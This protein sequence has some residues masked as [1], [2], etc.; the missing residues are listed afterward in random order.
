MC[1][2]IWWLG[3]EVL[4]NQF[5]LSQPS[6]AS[7]HRAILHAPS[8]IVMTKP[9]LLLLLLLLLILLSFYLSGGRLGLATHSL[10]WLPRKRDTKCID[11]YTYMYVF[12][13]MYACMCFTTAPSVALANW[14]WLFAAA[15]IVA[16]S[17]LGA[18]VGVGVATVVHLLLLLYCTILSLFVVCLRLVL[19]FC[20]IMFVCFIYKKV[21]SISI[22]YIPLCS[23]IHIY[24][25]VHVYVYVDV[26]GDV[27]LTLLPPSSPLFISI[28][29]TYGLLHTR[30]P[31]KM[32]VIAAIA[33]QIFGERACRQIKQEKSHP[34]VQRPEE[35]SAW[36]SM[37]GGIAIW[38]WKMPGYEWR[39]CL[40]L[41]WR[42]IQT[43]KH[44]WHI[45]IWRCIPV[46]RYFIGS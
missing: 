41:V 7:N 9:R 35:S 2:Y 26:Y 12:V 5:V 29:S 23:Y 1:T 10:P 46:G 25:Y 43:Y 27:C 31:S 45:H 32:A 4:R 6:A 44:L 37:D 38:I 11:M 19:S 8:T 18:C 40:Y 28:L 34:S 39:T 33:V 22:C 13:C 16:Y 30:S 24:E 21:N 3:C 20:G 36:T 14:F 17:C 15:L 42:H